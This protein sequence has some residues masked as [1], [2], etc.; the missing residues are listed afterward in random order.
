MGRICCASH[1]VQHGVDADVEID[2]PATGAAV[3]E[4]HG[5]GLDARVL[6]LLGVEVDADAGV[7][8]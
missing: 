3:E 5:E 2:G 8:R 4:V 1:D 7:R 6:G